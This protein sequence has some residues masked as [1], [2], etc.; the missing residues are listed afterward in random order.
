MHF[1][2]CIPE[3]FP[4]AFLHCSEVLVLVDL[5]S[6]IVTPFLFPLTQMVKDL[7]WRNLFLPAPIFQADKLVID[8]VGMFA[9]DVLLCSLGI[10]E[11]DH[12]LVLLALQTTNPL[13]PVS[14]L[15]LC[16]KLQLMD[17]SPSGFV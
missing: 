7:L 2:V 17:G 15:W 13:P 12:F 1:F 5:D 6:D 14:L 11:S 4:C 9:H 3:F 16:T 10:F 8:R